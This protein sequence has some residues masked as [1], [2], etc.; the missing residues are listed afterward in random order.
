MITS[1]QDYKGYKAMDGRILDNRGSGVKTN[2]HSGLNSGLESAKQG[3]DK[4]NPNSGTPTASGLQFALQQ[5]EQQ[6]VTIIVE[7]R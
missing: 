5:Y 4:I 2:L 1:Y 3:I 7:I 6:K